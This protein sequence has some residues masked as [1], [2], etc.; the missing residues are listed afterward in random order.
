MAAAPLHTSNSASVNIGAS[1][2]T[3]DVEVG[4]VLAGDKNEGN[5][6]YQGAP[7]EQLLG[8][9]ARRDERLDGHLQRIVAVLIGM[10][11]FLAVQAVVL[12]L[13]LLLVVQVSPRLVAGF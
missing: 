9:I 13:F 1:A 12:L 6:Y 3:G 4:D 10:T 11:A 7:A 2:Q 8:L 5:T